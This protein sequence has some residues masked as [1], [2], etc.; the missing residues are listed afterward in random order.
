MISGIVSDIHANLVALEA[1]LGDMPAVDRVVCLGDI[2]GYGPRPSE[3]CEIARERFS[4]CIAGNHDRC[5]VTPGTEEW[6]NE[7]ARTAIF[8]TRET[9][10]PDGARFLRALPD[11]AI[12]DDLTLMHGSLQ[13]PDEYITSPWNASPTLELTTSRLSLCG[14]THCAEAYAPG[15]DP[16]SC[17]R[18]ADGPAFELVVDRGQ[19]VLVNCGSVGQPR[20]G[21]PR[22]AYAVFD[23]D[24]GR[25]QLKRAAYDIEA[26]QED[27]LRLGLPYVLATRLSFG[28]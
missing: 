27:I 28:Q 15:R 10:S 8:W 17:D 24:S 26:T 12:V 20:D 21:D 9:L 11:T 22:A 19:K 18:I 7:A 6:F 5:V 25:L 3:C 1:V 14:H 16:D 13:D 23:S 4:V 2:V